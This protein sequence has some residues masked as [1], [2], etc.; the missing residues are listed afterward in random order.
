MSCKAISKAITYSDL[1]NAFPCKC[2]FMSLHRN[3]VDFTSNSFHCSVDCYTFLGRRHCLRDFAPDC[4]DCPGLKL[5]PNDRLYRFTFLDKASK[6][7]TSS[8]T[9]AHLW[10]SGWSHDAIGK[11]VSGAV[12]PTNAGHD[13]LSTWWWWPHRLPAES[14]DQW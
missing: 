3:S 13:L 5:P 8:G 1:R 12:L 14:H 10:W 4:R 6:C 7:V 2:P 11:H 9:N